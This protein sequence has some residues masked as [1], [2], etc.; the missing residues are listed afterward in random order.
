MTIHRWVCIVVVLSLMSV[1]VNEDSE[2]ERIG[3][4]RSVQYGGWVILLSSRQYATAE[5]SLLSLYQ[6]ATITIMK[7]RGTLWLTI[8][9][10]QSEAYIV[11]VL[12]LSSILMSSSL[13]SVVQRLKVLYCRRDNNNNETERDTTVDN[14][15]QYR[16]GL[17]LLS[18]CRC[19]QP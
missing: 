9:T 12:S 17:L 7:L 13:V 19:R 1:C 8:I 3:C 2:T 5:G 16:V 18:Y 10:I 6:Y 4:V 15:G 11:V 14:M